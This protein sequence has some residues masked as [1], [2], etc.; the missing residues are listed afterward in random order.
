MPIKIAGA[1]IGSRWEDPQK[2]L[3]K[4]EPF[5]RKAVDDGLSL[6]HISEPTRLLSISYDVFCLK[7]KTTPP[8]L[9]NDDYA[10]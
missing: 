4:A 3:Q 2:S 9:D 7:K 5:I 10:H 6:I 8:N 1:Q